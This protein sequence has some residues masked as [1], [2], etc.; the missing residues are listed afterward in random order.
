MIKKTLQ[1]LQSKVGLMVKGF[2]I[3]A[4]LASL[5]YWYEWRP[6]QI[7]KNCFE[8]T[9]EKFNEDYSFSRVGFDFIYKYC[10]QEK[11]LVR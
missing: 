4:L 5:F 8:S 2:L 11:G 1:I 10:L 3:A 9:K 7:R 6:M